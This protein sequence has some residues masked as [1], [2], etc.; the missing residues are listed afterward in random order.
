MT[1]HDGDD[2]HT[3]DAPASLASRSPALGVVTPDTRQVDFA[4]AGVLLTAVEALSALVGFAGTVYF[5]WVLGASALGVFFLFDAVLSTVA[6]VVDFGLR[7]AVEKRVSEGEHP[8]AT[9]GAALVLKIGLLCPFVVLAYPLAPVIDG[10]VGA[11]LTAA[12]VVGVLAYEF[13]LLTLY[14]LRAELRVAETAL[15]SF[16]RLLVYVVVAITLVQFDYGVRALV[17]AFVVSYLVLCVLGAARVSTR[18]ARPGR[19]QFRSLVRYAKYNGISAL[20]GYVYNTMDLLVVGYVLAPAFVAA[21]ELAWRVT[22]MLLL[23]T[24]AV[25]NTVFAQLSAWH[26]RGEHE[27]AGDT[28]AEALTASLFFVIPAAVGILLFGHDILGVVF[29]PEYVVA[30]LAFVVL[31]AEKLVTA[32]NVVLDAAVRAFDHPHAGA[33][34]T[35]VSATL[36][37]TLNLVLVPRYG[38]VGAAAATASAVVVHTLIVAGA[39]RRLAPLHANTHDLGWCA[40]AALIMGSVLL[41]AERVIGPTTPVGLAMLVAAGGVV[42]LGV[43]LI[44]P[45]LRAKALRVAR[46]IG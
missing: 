35:V 32:V 38:L 34:A 8:G 2:R 25:S 22:T 45:T 30:A 17:Y 29:G 1:G 37:V 18:P 44:D 41:G 9:L 16:G 36:N 23:V 39:L 21:Y 24:N 28:V 13:G 20:G 14:V 46:S 15:L 12:L 19:A 33:V 26:T 10:Y 4:R 7:D 31:G 5:A 27:R 6:T 11:P 3:A 42:Y 43:V 40:L